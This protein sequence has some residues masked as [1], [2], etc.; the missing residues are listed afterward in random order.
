MD[1]H[2]AQEEGTGFFTFT[3]FQSGP[4][5]LI[6]LGGTACAR[7][8][9]Q[10]KDAAKGKDNGSQW[11]LHTPYIGE[12]GK[13]LEILP[14]S[15][16][17]GLGASPACGGGPGY[18]LVSFAWEAKGY[19]FYPLRESKPLCGFDF[20]EFHFVK[21]QGKPSKLHVPGQGCPAPRPLTR[22]GKKGYG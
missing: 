7:Q 13:E 22:A 20:A 3:V 15:S 4:D 18:P 6:R 5:I 21:I 14:F 19:R 8:E 2:L 10:G 16:S 17:L 12:T 11:V 1:I 9:S